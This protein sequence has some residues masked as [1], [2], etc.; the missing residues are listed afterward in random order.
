MSIPAVAIIGGGF[1]GTLTAVHLLRGARR[2]L[3]IVLIERSLRVGRGLA[4]GTIDHDHLLNVPAG[5]MSALPDDPEHFLRWF[6]QRRPGAVAGDFA[7]RAAYGQYVQELL[8][9]AAHGAA[10]GVRYERRIAGAIDVQLDGPR[11]ATVRLDDDTEL[12][13]QRVILAL[14]VF[15]PADLLPAGGDARLGARYIRNVWAP[16]ALESVKPEDRVLLLGS[17]LTMVD[18]AL[19]L[20]RTPRA[21]PLLVL[22]RRG[23][24]PQ[25]HAPFTPLAQP[26][27]RGALPTTTRALVH[28]IRQTVAEHMAG[29]GDWRA[30]I[31]SLRPISAELWQCL[32]HA[33]KARFFR[34]VR[35]FW[36]VHRHRMAPCAAER[37]AALCAAQ[38]VRI[39]AG[40]VRSAAPAPDGLRVEWAP[41][42][43]PSLEHVTVDYVISCTG[44]QADFSK[45]SDPLVARLRERGLI[46]PD[47]LGIGLETG[48]EGAVCERGGAAS[49]VL[50][51]IGAARRPALYETTAV[52]E[53]R[54]QAARLAQH[55]LAGLAG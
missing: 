51:T 26:A 47:P 44:A 9:S 28:S 4:Y 30:V 10:A 12:R 22:S 17:G 55:L 1:S 32:P 29:G 42:G 25:R 45:L 8:E 52:P 14:G 11:L 46:R 13:A 6:A 18:V 31:D 5:R 15:P 35:P 37:F 3:R 21:T 40:R 19:T 36:D 49:K 41:R 27:L 39:A 48:A 50:F 24:W 38:R 16:G 20:T 33:E 53:L 43:R 54:V 34:H 2:P 23:L 7:P